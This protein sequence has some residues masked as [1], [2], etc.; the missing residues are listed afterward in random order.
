MSENNN[1][2]LLRDFIKDLPSNHLCLIVKDID[3]TINVLS[4]VLG[5]R[6]WMYPTDFE[7]AQMVEG[8]KL[9][10]KVVVGKLDNVSLGQLNLTLLQT[11][12]EGT[13]FDHFLK[14]KGEGLHHIGVTV[15]NYDE[16][17]SRIE[18]MGFPKILS[19]DNPDGARWCHFE[20]NPGGLML[21]VLSEKGPDYEAL[22][23]IIKQM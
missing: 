22:G 13:I 12:T 15:A 11:L 3:K 20:L 23:A 10:N 8:K 7:K 16:V 6:Q 18:K 21:E 9:K 14:T 1:I 4:V 19:V 5:I 2:N 17:I